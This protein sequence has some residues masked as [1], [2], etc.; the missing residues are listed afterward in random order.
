M[1]ELLKGMNKGQYLL[2]AEA[3]HVIEREMDKYHAWK[4]CAAAERHSVG[5]HRRSNHV[6]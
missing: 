1:T 2:L 6:I 3:I 5:I 4:K